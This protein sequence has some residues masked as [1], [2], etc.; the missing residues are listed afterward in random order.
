M[1]DDFGTAGARRGERAR[2][3]EALR[4]NYRRHRDTIAAL[5]AEA[6]SAALA[7]EYRRVI[8]GI[9]ASLAKLDEIDGRTVTPEAPLR[10]KTDAGARPLVTTPMD[11]EVTPMDLPAAPPPSNL[12]IALIVLV[13]LAVLGAIGWMIWRASRDREP[14]PT[15]VEQPAVTEST[16]TATRATDTM[17]EPAPPAAAAD[18]ALVLKP[19]THDYGV[20]RK[21]TRATRQFEITNRTDEPVT[22]QIAR[23]L[24]H[25]LYYEHAPV[26]P[27]KGK[28]SIT[29]TIDGARAKAGELRETLKVTSKKDPT[30]STSF[31]VTATV[32]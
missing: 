15:I 6:P 29:V 20:I 24:C 28:E 19:R 1:S 30:V 5:M 9:D 22:I 4:Q 2:E 32:R 10:L 3:I 17:T 13:A 26:V 18:D 8:T 31:E 25:C 12:R 11:D 23:S 7:E 16:T 14:Q 21:G 27:P